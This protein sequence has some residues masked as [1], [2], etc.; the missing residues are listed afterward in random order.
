MTIKSFSHIGE[1][2]RQE[3]NFVVSSDQRLYIL[4]D[5][6]GGLEQGKIAS[7]LVC[8]SVLSNYE[9]RKNNFKHREISRLVLA[10]QKALN[11]AAI[12]NSNYFNISTAYIIIYSYKDQISVS[13]MGGCKAIL[14]NPEKGLIWESRCDMF[15]QEVDNDD[16]E[17]ES[18][19]K[20]RCRLVR[21]NYNFLKAMITPL[22]PAQ[23]VTLRIRVPK[24]RIILMGSHGIFDN[25]NSQYLVDILTNRD[26]N[27]EE[28]WNSFK[29]FCK[30]N[31]VENYSAILISN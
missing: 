21:G 28:R 2:N 18:D 16:D 14:M 12:E 1:E 13:H 4:C 25:C 26:Y 17:T 7:H 20:Q 22:I 19:G 5:G 31:S 15:S 11:I 30:S 24:D 10:A 23:N 6:V 9:Q 8:K 27:D 29:G 3:D